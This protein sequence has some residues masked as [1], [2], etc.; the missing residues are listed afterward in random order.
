MLNVLELPT[1]RIEDTDPFWVGKLSM[2]IALA[3]SRLEFQTD[4]RDDLEHTLGEFLRSPLP[5]EGLK[6]TLRE[7]MKR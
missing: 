6:K 4:V 5:S 3:V 1:E 7:E 2:S